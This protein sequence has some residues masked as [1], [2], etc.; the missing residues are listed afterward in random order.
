MVGAT[1]PRTTAEAMTP[2]ERRGRGAGAGAVRMADPSS[3]VVTFREGRSGANKKEDT[4]E[5]WTTGGRRGC[6]EGARGDPGDAIGSSG[7]LEARGSPAT[8]PRARRARP[9]FPGFRP[10]SGRTGDGRFRPVIRGRVLVL[11]QD[12]A[13]ARGGRASERLDV[14]GL[15][16]H[17]GGGDGGA[18]S[19]RLH[20]YLPRVVAMDCATPSPRVRQPITARFILDDGGWTR[21][22][23]RI[24]TDVVL[25]SQSVF[26]VAPCCPAVAELSIL[27]FRGIFSARFIPAVPAAR[28]FRLALACDEKKHCGQ[29]PLPL[30][31]QRRARGGC[32]HAVRF[33]ARVATLARVTGRRSRSSAIARRVSAP[34]AVPAGGDLA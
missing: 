18:R 28:R 13:D 33:E 12:R 7:V 8:R 14:L 26:F 25:D 31:R 19:E 30:P 15:D 2:D 3:S 22:A 11:V 9:D 23:S 5:G 1:P 27:G 10:G 34:S 17:H 20:G 4:R 29:P 24:T 32:R 16:P 6:F 21:S